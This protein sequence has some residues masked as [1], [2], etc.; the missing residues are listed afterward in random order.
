MTFKSASIAVITAASLAFS[1]AAMP[2][3]A[4][5]I[6]PDEPAVSAEAFSDEQLQTFAVAYLQIDRISQ[7]YETRLQSAETPEEQQQIQ[8][9]ANDEM[10]L[11]VEQTEG[12]TVDEYNAIFQAAQ[13]DQTVLAQI[14][15]HLNALAQ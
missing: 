9:E 7:E 13:T 5:E 14:E 15:S 6:L 1:A 2:A 12:L 11:V 3:L 10:V 4:Q 8:M